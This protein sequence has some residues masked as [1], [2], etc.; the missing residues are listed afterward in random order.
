MTKCGL[1]SRLCIYFW[2]CT[3]AEMHRKTHENNTHT[4]THTHLRCCTNLQ[5]GQTAN[6][7]N[8][9]L[10]A[11]STYTFTAQPWARGERMSMQCTHSDTHYEHRVE[12]MHTPVF[13]SNEDEDNYTTVALL[14][15]LSIW[16]VFY[17]VI[18]LFCR[19]LLMVPFVL[20]MVVYVS[21]EHLFFCDFQIY[22]TKRN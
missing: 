4:H 18:T 8:Q 2:C 10:T 15:H 5:Q 16:P 1:Q 13:D 6:V 3:E 12:H 7:T 19:T 9:S 22:S 20:C 11:V 14:F 17:A 21:M